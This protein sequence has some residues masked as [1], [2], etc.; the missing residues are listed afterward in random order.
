[1]IRY[2]LAE[3]CFERIDIFEQK[4]SCG[5]LW[6]YSPSDET[7]RPPVSTL[8]ASEKSVHDKWD[9]HYD[10]GAID[11]VSP[12]YDGLETNI[13]HFL[14]EFSNDESLRCNQ[15]FPTRER[16]LEYLE[17]YAAEQ[18]VKF[19]TK[20]LNITLKGDNLRK[21]WLVESKELQSGK[22]E[23]TMYDAVVVAS[24]HYSVPYVPTIP[25]MQ[26]WDQNY[27][28][29][30]SHS[31]TYQRPQHFAGKKVLIV[32]YAASGRD[33]ASQIS[34]SSALPIILSQRSNLLGDD[35]PSYLKPMPEIKCFLPP[36]AGDRAIRFKNNHTE[37]QID[38]I[39]F[40]TGYYYSYPFL[41]S[42]SPPNGPPFITTGERVQGLYRHIFSISHPQIAFL[43][44]LKPIIPFRTCEGQSAVI[45]KIWSGRLQL[46]STDEMHRWEE[47]E[48]ARK[49][50]GK[51]FHDVP[52]PEDFDY[53]DALVTWATQ[54]QG[55]ASLGVGTVPPKWSPKERWVRKRLLAIKEAFAAK[56]EARHGI[57]TM[58][59]LGFRYDEA[60]N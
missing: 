59:E 32:G 48:I 50:A 30:I 51:R 37:T 45:A 4:S 2:L 49:G 54:G 16:T 15:L 28:G 22:N 23:R 39:V 5:G 42:I 57:R 40:C 3:E 12:M 27:P 36:S 46:P 10:H 9:H 31:K 29:T 25:G 58:E 34:T 24:G 44:L 52:T 56:G 53:Y 38:A 21:S 6:N 19:N 55:Q 1:M 14:M 33:I 17:N 18:I 8:V 26:E 43:G 35:G 11:A 20:V 7:H 41:S 60:D 47:Y 13:P